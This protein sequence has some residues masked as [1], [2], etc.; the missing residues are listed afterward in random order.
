VY[1]LGP[2]ESGVLHALAREDGEAR[3][4][5]AAVTRIDEVSVLAEI[6]GS[7]P[8]EDVRAEAVRGLAG[9]AAEA[10]EA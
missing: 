5:R 6:A 3:V 9:V 1:G 4:R 10:V 2:D 7:D 8:D